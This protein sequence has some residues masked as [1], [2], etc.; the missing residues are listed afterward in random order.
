MHLTE[1]KYILARYNEPSENANI[2]TPSDYAIN[3][4]IY[5]TA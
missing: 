4:E 1:S 2:L 5:E 3:R